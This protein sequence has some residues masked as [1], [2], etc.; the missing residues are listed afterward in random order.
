MQPGRRRQMIEKQSGSIK[1]RRLRGLPIMLGA[2]LLSGCIASP[3]FA[4][5]EDHQAFIDAY[6]AQSL[7]AADLRQA[8]EAAS[9]KELRVGQAASGDGLTL[10][11]D[12]DQADLSRV[13]ALILGQQVVQY[14]ASDLVFRGRVSARFSDLPL[15]E[16]LNILLAQSGYQAILEN[17]ILRFEA[18]AALTPRPDDLARSSSGMIS[19]EVGLQHL[20][21]ADV[22]QLIS[23]LFADEDDEGPLL[24]IGSVP[25]L[26]AVYVSGPANR[27]AEAMAVIARADRPVSHV[28]IEVLIVDIDTSSVE[29]LNLTWQDGASGKFSG[30][31]LIP[32]LTGGNLAATFS[33]LAGDAAS[34]SA[35]IDFLAAQ[36]VAHV[37]A[38]PYIATRSTKPASLAIV[39][40]QFA[41]V[42]TS[43]DDSSIITTDSITAGISMQ[44]TPIV[45]ADESVRLDVT[46]EDSRFGET[47]GDIVIT[48][49]RNTASTSMV[50]RSGQ[51]IVIGGLNAKYRISE[52]SGIPW[53]RGIPLLK[54]FA[55]NQGALETRNE[56]MVYLT[57]YV[58]VP[59][60]DLP[61]PLLGEPSAVMPDL[62]SL[63]TFGRTSEARETD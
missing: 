16:G 46:L 18:G 21:A 50:V 36:N 45:M 39:D 2:A 60:L 42:D 52:N 24:T 23:D 51:T 17:G 6:R 13:M 32:G 5:G 44:I 37:I 20:A 8:Q 53:L 31:N 55:A 48:K 58:W 4:D 40:D 14:R 27:V 41:R 62:T 56:L 15:A 47:A 25:E 10:S 57:P 3:D 33:D 12:L 7:E 59:G 34:V 26:N 61:M 19:R 49:E 54:A 9:I 63:E 30:I 28:I 38:R 1:N 29:A 22:V 35:T 11:V 43:G